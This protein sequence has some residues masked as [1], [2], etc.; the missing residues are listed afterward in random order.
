MRP[1]A[2]L[3]LYTC[4]LCSAQ[5][6]LTWPRQIGMLNAS[7]PL[8]FPLFN[9]QRAPVAEKGAGSVKE[10]RPTVPRRDQEQPKGVPVLVGT[11]ILGVMMLISVWWL[12][13]SD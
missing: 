7:K 3:C 12:D 2:A 6:S 9:R 5:G 10:E 13:K 11:L 8:R 4:L 1:A